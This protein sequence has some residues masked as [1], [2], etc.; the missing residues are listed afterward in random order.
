M[1]RRGIGQPPPPAPVSPLEEKVDY[2][3]RAVKALTEP[4]VGETTQ[5]KF[6]E[7]LQPSTGIRV[8]EDSPFNATIISICFHFPP[9]CE[10]LVDVMVG[11]G[12]IQCF[13]RNGYLSLDSATPVFGTNE[14]VNKSERIWVEIANSDLLNPHTISVVLTLQE[15]GAS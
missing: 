15:R 7:K 12:H 13:P 3:V 2:L 10:G 5:I 6:H 4:V 14:L 9:G 1:Q 11:H 8:S